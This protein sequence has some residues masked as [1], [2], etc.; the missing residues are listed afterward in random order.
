MMTFCLFKFEYIF[1]GVFIKNRKQKIVRVHI[2]VFLFFVLKFLRQSFSQLFFVNSK[3]T[4]LFII[5]QIIIIFDFN[6]Q[7]KLNFSPKYNL[8]FSTSKFGIYFF[9]PFHFLYLNNKFPI[10]RCQLAHLNLIIISM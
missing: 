3:S 7:L 8:K 10:I 4:K 5:F 6:Y 9:P 2:L 1:Q